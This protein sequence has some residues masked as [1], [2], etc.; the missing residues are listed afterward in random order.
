[1]IALFYAS[2]DRSQ[3]REF[4][5]SSLL[6][7]LFDLA[8]RFTNFKILVEVGLDFARYSLTGLRFGIVVEWIARIESS[9][10]KIV[11]TN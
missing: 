11:E 9:F 10:A 1:M 2:Q 3:G 8:R 4:L 7:S 6:R 5:R